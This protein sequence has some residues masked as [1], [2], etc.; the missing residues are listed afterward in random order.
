MKALLLAAG[1]GTRLRPLTNYVP[2]CLVPINGKP[3]LSYWLDN[4]EAAGIDDFLI[5]THY[6]SEQVSEFVENSSY[7]DKITLIYEDKLLLTAGTVLKNKE[8][9]KDEPFMLVHADNLSF[10]NFKEFIEVHKRRPKNTLITMMVFKTDTPKSC[11]IVEVG[12]DKT[13]I[14][15]YEKSNEDVGNLANAA[16]YIVE[17]EVIK[18][19]ESIGKEEID[20]S[21]EVIP[22]FINKISVYENDVYHR[23]IGTLESYALANYHMSKNIYNSEVVDE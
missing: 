21:I 15:F 9:L 22:H 10:C 13:V 1:L 16:V 4:L 18:F 20:F 19:L 17:P 14:N 7:K 12:A 23:D 3:L 8:L 6:F 2:K 5:N 11:G